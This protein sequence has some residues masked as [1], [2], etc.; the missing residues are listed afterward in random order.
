[1]A[2]KAEITL[3]SGT[4]DTKTHEVNH[5]K[6]NFLL[7][8]KSHLGFH[9]RRSSVVIEI[10]ERGQKILPTRARGHSWAVAGLTE[11]VP[12]AGAAQPVTKSL[13][14]HN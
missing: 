6:A 2:T 8:L 5:P 14:S 4:L 10:I 11:A 12:S 1:M 3:V 9:S 7:Q 13:C